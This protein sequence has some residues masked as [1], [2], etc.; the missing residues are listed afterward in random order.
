MQ[1][2][3]ITYKTKNLVSNELAESYRLLQINEA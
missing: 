1:T 3:S 2:Y